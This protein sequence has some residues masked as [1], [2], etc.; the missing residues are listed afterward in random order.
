MGLG[1]R[2]VNATKRQM[3]FAHIPAQ[4][5]NEIAANPASAAMVSWYLL[6]NPG[7]QI[8]FVPDTGEIRD[9]AFSLEAI[10]GYEE[11]TDDVVAEL[12]EAGILVDHGRRVFWPDEP[13]TYIR[14][15]AN[16]WFPVNCWYGEGDGRS[17]AENLSE[18][19]TKRE[20]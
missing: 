14:K 6:R 8:S 4:T 20:H 12:I 13:E 17:D 11:V 16:R 15:L 9:A 10:A 1:Y 7:D 19:S 2:L 18:N 5:M 3:I